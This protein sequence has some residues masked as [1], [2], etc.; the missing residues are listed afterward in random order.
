LYPIKTYQ[1]LESDP[2][3]NIAG[4]LSKLE[5]DESAVIQVLLKPINDDWQHHSAKESSKIMSGKIS[6]FT[7]NP[8]KLV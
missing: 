3:N 2:I 4:A 5:E 7:L 6:K 8:I 1:K